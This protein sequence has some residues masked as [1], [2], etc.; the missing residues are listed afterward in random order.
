MLL[1][2]SQARA[3]YEYATKQQFAILAVNADS[4]AAVLDTLEAARSQN[5]PVIVETSLWQ[6]TGHSF[7][8]GD[9]HVGIARYLTDLAVWAHSDRYRDTPVVYHTDHIKGPQ[10]KTLLQAAIRGIK[11]RIGTQSCRLVASS[12]SLDSS[13]LS[14]EANVAL[15]KAL[16][17]TAIEQS[18]KATLEMEAGVDQGVT[19]IEDTEKIFG[20][21]ERSH[22]GHLALWAPGVGTLH[23]FG[24]GNRVDP[25]AIARHQTLASQICHR[26]IG[27]ALH[28]SSGLTDEA[29]T[30]AVAAGTV[31]VNWSS[32]SLLIR[33]QAARDFYTEH[34]AQLER[35]HPEFKQTAMDNGVQSYIA[36]RYLPL[37]AERIKLL[38][39]HG[40]GPRFIASLNN[41]ASRST[42]Q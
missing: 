28:G 32:E 11:T 37:V 12:V 20:A 25:E 17:E 23:G 2:P 35:H 16:C 10:T 33:S 38:G 24:S 30:E 41:P 8:C 22:P 40:H 7:G 18:E 31:K 4:P 15:M 1:T 9:P 36:E 39:A 42:D 19:P 29:L 21:V 27:L 5:A 26:P 34:A 3:L 6:L 13:E 14:P